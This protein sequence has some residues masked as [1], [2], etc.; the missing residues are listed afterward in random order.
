YIDPSYMI[1]SSVAVPTDSVYCSQLGN[2]AAHAAMA[3]KTKTLI[4]LVNNHYVHLPIELVVASRNYVDPQSSMWRS[5]IE[6]THQPVMMTNTKEA[7][8]TTAEQKRKLKK[9]DSRK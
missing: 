3:G 5:V 1:R 9:E 4:G 7:I 6:A 8:E 2:N